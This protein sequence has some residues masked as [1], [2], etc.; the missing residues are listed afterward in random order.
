[1]TDERLSTNLPGTFHVTESSSEIESESSA[2]DFVPD[3]PFGLPAFGRTNPRYSAR[4]AQSPSFGISPRHRNE[5]DLDDHLDP[6]ETAHGNGTPTV[7]FNG[8]D[9]KR[10]AESSLDSIGRCFIQLNAP[11]NKWPVNSVETLE[12]VYLGE[13]HQD[14]NRPEAEGTFVS[15]EDIPLGSGVNENRNCA[16]DQEK[17]EPPIPSSLPLWRV[18]GAS[19]DEE[20]DDIRIGNTAVN[21]EE[22]EGPS[23]PLIDGIGV[24]R[25]EQTESDSAVSAS[26]EKAETRIE[27]EEEED[28]EGKDAITPGQI[29]LSDNGDQDSSDMLVQDLQAS[30]GLSS[31]RKEIPEERDSQLSRLIQDSIVDLED[32]DFGLSDGKSEPASGQRSTQSAGFTD[33]EDE[34]EVV[35]R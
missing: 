14:S 23:E 35:D 33:D 4:K 17:E 10:V 1:M 26:Q 2:G 34:F 8:S 12:A 22:E 16:S 28:D 24:P 30:D 3:A 9:H 21:E 27:E 31:L 5:S 18:S 19:L 29:R 13:D 15:E 7:E 11:D 6:D 20:E 25:L 32:F